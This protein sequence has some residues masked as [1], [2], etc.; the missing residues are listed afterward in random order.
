VVSS[1]RI[2]LISDIPEA[3]S[4]SIFGVDVNL[5]NISKVSLR[6]MSTLMMEAD[7]VIETFHVN[8][9]FT[10]LIENTLL[11]TDVLGYIPCLYCHEVL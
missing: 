4:A 11:R 10:L 6:L 7:M 3:V 2:E 5:S 9:I 8:S 1:L